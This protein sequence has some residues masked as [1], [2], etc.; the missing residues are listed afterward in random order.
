MGRNQ[1][2]EREVSS[3][4]GISLVRTILILRPNGKKYIIPTMYLTTSKSSQG[5]QDP[6]AKGSSFCRRGQ[7]T[8]EA[9]KKHRLRGWESEL[10]LQQPP[11]AGDR[12]GIWGYGGS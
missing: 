1:S 3:H 10:S 8:K 4:D 12:N 6:R 7:K 5:G 9:A 2:K 11:G